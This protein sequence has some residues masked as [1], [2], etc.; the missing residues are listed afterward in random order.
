L[1][2]DKNPKNQIDQLFIGSISL[3]DRRELNK[4]ATPNATEK[5]KIV[6][7]VKPPMTSDPGG[8]RIAVNHLKRLYEIVDLIQA[9]TVMLVLRYPSDGDVD[10]HKKQH[11]LEKM[12]EEL[13][14]FPIHS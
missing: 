10:C 1:I 11:K 14:S 5:A 7:R 8:N 3:N 13:R 2:Q 12:F 9:L 6:P 4:S